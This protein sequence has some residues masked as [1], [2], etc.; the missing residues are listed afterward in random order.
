MATLPHSVPS[1]LSVLTA[2]LYGREDATLIAWQRTCT[3][4]SDALRVQ[5]AGD[6]LTK[7]L[8]LAQDGSVELASDDRALVHSGD[9][10]Y[11]VLADG[12]CA[13]PDYVHR[14][15]PCKHALAVLIH[16]QALALLEPAG[17]VPAP[18]TP[19]APAAPRR[20]ATPP[21]AV[22]ASAAWQ[23]QEAQTSACMRWRIG[24]M[25][26][27]YTIRGTT[28]AE[29]IDRIDATVQRLHDLFEVYELR[30]AER[31]TA[32]TAVL[33]QAQAQ[34]PQAPA[35]PDVHALVQ[36]AVQQALA[37]QSNGQA[38]PPLSTSQAKRQAKSRDQ[39]TGVC[40][41]HTIDMDFHDNE[42]GTWYSHLLENG[43]YCKGAK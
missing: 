7:A 25:E 1:R 28:D 9:Q 13:C 41:L 24:T 40:S 4:V 10:R 21:P 35:P 6:R 17:A 14:G 18:S 31:A 5:H 27:T 22:P 29:V 12:T 20:G 3:Q 2:E 15:T 36:Q 32:R 34:A 26:V 43:R 38:A 33:T 8:A 30:A 16:T 42:R 19:A 39:E 23:V 37:A 11:A